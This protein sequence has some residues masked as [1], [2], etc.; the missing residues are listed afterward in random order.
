MRWPWS[1]ENLTIYSTICNISS[2]KHELAK[3]NA[4]HA[5]HAHGYFMRMREE[6]DIPKSYLP[7]PKSYILLGFSAYIMNGNIIN[8]HLPR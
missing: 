7:P 2:Y 3:T 6:Y 8:A 1:D 4:L 5:I